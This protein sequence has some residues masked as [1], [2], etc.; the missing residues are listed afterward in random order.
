V[1]VSG[2]VSQTVF[3]T[4]RVIDHA[5]RKCKLFP[6]AVGAEQL[7]VAQD[8]L[9]LLLSSLA[10]R[11]LQLWCIEK[12]ILPMYINQ[13]A[14]PVPY[15]T[16]TK[17]VNDL[18]NTN[19]RTIEYLTP[20]VETVAADRVTFTLSQAD[21]VTTVGVLWSGASVGLYLETSIDGITW[22]VEKTV[23]DPQLTAG[24][25]LWVDID[26]AATTI[27]FRVRAVTGTLN[28]ADVLIGN[29]PREIVMA[30]LNRD[31]YSNLPNKT[32][33]GRPLQF[34]LDRTLNEPVMYI[35]PVPDANSALAQIVTYVKRYIMDVGSLTQEIEVPQRWYEAIVYQ[36][37]ARLAEDLPQVDPSLLM[38]LDQKAIRALNEA[39]MEERDNSPIYFTPNISIYTR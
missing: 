39:E 19:Y 23:S 1:A 5:F 31:S 16:Q 3:N 18:L 15:G 30:R 2:T 11:G 17:G 12:L 26:G 8:N 7:E 35:W 24:E 25:W 10:N 9:Y 29:T 33:Q 4:R 36:L 21:T 13:A 28:Q 32:F 37:A 38:V 6:E 20:A 34:W 27:Y 22:V 14:V